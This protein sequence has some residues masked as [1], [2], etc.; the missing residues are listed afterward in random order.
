MAGKRTR[1]AKPGDADFSTSRATR[2]LGHCQATTG[3]SQTERWGKESRRCW[4]FS[5]LWSWCHCLY[6]RT[7]A[8]FMCQWPWLP[9]QRSQIFGR[10]KLEGEDHAL[11]RSA[12]RNLLPSCPPTTSSWGQLGIWVMVAQFTSLVGSR[13][14]ILYRCVV[15]CIWRL[16]WRVRIL[17]LMRCLGVASGFSEFES[18][19]SYDYIATCSDAKE[20]GG[21][22]FFFL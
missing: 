7:V 15:T 3:A 22:T 9:A 12:R 16:P 19:F 5:K 2:P 10:K 1:G 11:C 13:V 14:S 4:W 20:E 6:C 21:W 17:I 8:S 18:G